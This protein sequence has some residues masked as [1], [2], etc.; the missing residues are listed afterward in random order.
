ML[1]DLLSS[2]NPSTVVNLCL[3]HFC[4]QKYE[5]IIQKCEQ[6]NNV[7]NLSSG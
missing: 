3:L 4:H 6:H 5:I 1:I 2:T 7:D